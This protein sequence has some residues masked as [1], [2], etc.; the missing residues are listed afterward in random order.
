MS[1]LNAGNVAAKQAA[2][3]FDVSLGEFLF[4]A[5][6]AK[7]VAYNHTGIVSLR[8][9]KGKPRAAWLALP[10][11]EQLPQLF[12]SGFLSWIHRILF[13]PFQQLRDIDNMSCRLLVNFHF[14]SL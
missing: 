7:A 13:N 8:R 3:L 2:A 5:E 1:I 10:F 4:L 11:S 14:D 9:M 12:F 6:C